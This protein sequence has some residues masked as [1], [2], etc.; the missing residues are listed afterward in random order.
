MC[1]IRTVSTQF[2]LL[3]VLGMGF[4]CLLLTDAKTSRGVILEEGKEDNE[5]TSQVE[6]PGEPQAPSTSY[7]NGNYTT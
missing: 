7:R 3:T 1:F 4:S 5:S 6:G 2:L